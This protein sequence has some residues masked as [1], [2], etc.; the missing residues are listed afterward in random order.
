MNTGRLLALVRKEMFE[1][2]RDT[3]LLVFL[4]YAF[5]GDILLAAKGIRL[6]LHNAAIG[7]V[8]QNHSAFSRDLIYEF[9]P[10]YFRV[11][12]AK[13]EKALLEQLDA[14]DDVAGLVIPPKFE[15]N[16]EQLGSAQVQLF[17]DGTRASQASLAE[18]YAREIAA[19][20]SERLAIRR[21][22]LGPEAFRAMPIVTPELRV[23][24]N[25]NRNESWFQ[26]LEEMLMMMSLLAVTLPAA[27]LVREREHGTIEQL[28]V[29]PV[30]S[31]EIVLAKCVA[32]TITLVFFTAI[33]V[34]GLLVP[35]LG[36]PV[37]GSLVLFFVSTAIFV[38]TM[39]GLGLL[40]ASVCRT[41]PQVAMVAILVAAPILFLSGAW[42]PPEAMPAWFA[43]LTFLSPL[44]WFNDITLGIFLRGATVKDLASSFLTMTG[45]GMLF[46][47]WGVWR[48]RS[49]LD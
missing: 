3:V 1:L 7:V 43:H 4:I 29:S 45:L 40:V 37:R 24:F 12:Y 25:P 36:V 13:S 35:I 22:G 23:S 27:A 15:S 47:L 42:T 6:D 17:L 48:L 2:S 38:F 31:W 30:S 14:G 5:T 21:L 32:S 33:T 46:F 34:L 8:N 44:R 39:S 26:G 49:R 41:M 18:G 28:L 16:I 20:L 19:R 9:A 10:P 11:R